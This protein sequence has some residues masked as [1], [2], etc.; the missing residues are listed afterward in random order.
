[1]NK[2]LIKNKAISIFT[3][4]IILT[5]LYGTC[6]MWFYRSIEVDVMKPVQLIYDGESGVAHVR[7]QT[8]NNH[9]NQRISQFYDSVSY[10]VKPNEDLKNGDTIMV[11]ASFD[12]DL[13]KRYHIQP[14]HTQME[15]IVEQLPEKI[16]SIFQLPYEYQ[17]ALKERGEAYLDKN[18][19]N[20]LTND[21]YDVD[22]EA[23][24]EFEQREF[25]TRYF[26][27]AHDVQQHDRILDI[28]LLHGNQDVIC[29]G[30]T[31][32]GIN[33]S[34]DANQVNV[35]GEKLYFHEEHDYKDEKQLSTLLKRR[36]HMYDLYELNTNE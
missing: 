34:F 19:K 11:Y 24:E 25:I 36:Y 9:V 13:A 20:I 16:D 15:V 6:Y 18:E 2:D 22:M 28:Y 35:Y 7:V 14:Y 26:L 4:V 27:K 12:Q 32:S 3:M 33:T 17:N 30:V 1:M 29:Y 31:Y 8:Q 5:V 21:F 10:Q 23:E